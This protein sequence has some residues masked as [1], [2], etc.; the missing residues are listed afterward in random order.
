MKKSTKN[1]LYGCDITE[2]QISEL[3]I[4]LGF[5]MAHKGF[6]YIKYTIMLAIHESDSYLYNLSTMLYPRLADEFKTSTSGVERAIRY[7]IEFAHTTFMLSSNKTV[8]DYFYG[9]NKHK[10]TNLKFL[11]TLAEYI[12]NNYRNF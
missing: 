7:S 9:Y 5:S 1:I 4:Q 11:T 12:K 10:L 8:F 2:K 6:H 3:L